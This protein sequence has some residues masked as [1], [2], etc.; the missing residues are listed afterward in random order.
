MVPRQ[1]PTV[2]WLHQFFWFLPQGSYLISG[3][4]GSC[5]IAWVPLVGFLGFDL[6]SL[7]PRIPVEPEE[8][9]KQGT[10]DTWNQNIRTRLTSGFRINPLMQIQQGVSKSP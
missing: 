4:Y 5:F 9:W 3:S 1:V 7:V 10:V 6:V 8:P 2:P